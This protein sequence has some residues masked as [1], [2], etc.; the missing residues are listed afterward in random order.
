MKMMSIS[1]TV[2]DAQ[3]SVVLKQGASTFGEQPARV[4]RQATLDGGAVIVHS[5]ASHGD[6]TFRID[7][8]IDEGQKTLMEHIHQNSTLVLISCSEGLFLGAISTITASNGA[9]TATILIK[10]KEA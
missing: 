5:G 6:R 9:L 8:K 2:S 10:E 3:G 1:M 4:S 7:T